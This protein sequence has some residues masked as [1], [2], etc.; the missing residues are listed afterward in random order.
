[1]VTHV[2]DNIGWKKK[3]PQRTKPH[4]TNSILVQKC[5]TKEDLAKIY[6]EPKYDFD[7]KKYWS[8]KGKHQKLPSV[9]FKRAK[10]KLLSYPS[11]HKHQEYDRSSLKTLTWMYTR[12]HK[13][14]SSNNQKISAW[15]AFQELSTQVLPNEVNVRYL[16][17]IAESPTKMK[18]IY[19]AIYRSLDIMD[20]SDIKFIF[21]EVDE[22]VHEKVL[23]AMFNMEAEGFE[24][25][26][27][28]MPRISWFHIGIC[29]LMT[30]YEQLN[31]YGIIELLSAAGLAKKVR[32]REI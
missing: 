32:L 16:P 6:F 1:M 26:K 15:S 10:P 9:K 17:P 21:L 3:N 14:D 12:L 11:H 25:F 13:N 18:V 30:I 31:K 4:H 24:I 29:M 2:F 27:K 7:R 22:A 23:D 8:Y 19:D 5:D 20:E 28:V